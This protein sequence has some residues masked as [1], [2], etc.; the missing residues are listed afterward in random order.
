MVLAIRE[1]IDRAYS[2]RSDARPK[3]VKTTYMKY[4]TARLGEFG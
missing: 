4:A 3:V 2:G 1:E